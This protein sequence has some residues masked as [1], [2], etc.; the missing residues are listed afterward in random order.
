MVWSRLR[1]PA[2]FLVTA[3][4]LA[5]LTAVGCGEAATTAPEAPAT[6]APAPAATEAPAPVTATNPQAP[7]PA[8]APT[9]APTP[10]QASVVASGQMSLAWHAGL[11]S[12]WLDPQDN[13]AMATPYNFAYALHD[14]VVKIMPQALNTPSLAESWEWADDFSSITIKMRPGTSF[15]NGDP[16]TVEDVKFTFENYSG[17]QADILHGASAGVEIVDPSTIRFSFNEPFL[18]FLLLYGT[19]SSGAG[20]VVPSAYYQEVGNEGFIRAPVGAGPY[21]LL[22]EIPGDSL[23]FEAFENYHR[24]VHVKDFTMRSVQEPT[25][26]LALI[27][28]GDVDIAYNIAGELIPRVESN[29]EL[30]LVPTN[31]TAVFWLEFPHM[32]NSDNPFS[33]ARVREAVGLALDRQAI[34]D[35]ETSGHSKPANYWIPPNIL[36]APPHEAPEEDLE[37]ARQLMADAGYADGIEVEWLSPIPNYF[38]L[39]ERIISQIGRIGIS[40]KLQTMERGTFFDRLA[41]G[42]TWQERNDAWGAE[43]QILLIGTGTAGAFIAR[44]DAYVGCEAASSRMCDPEIDALTQQYKA[45]V[46]PAEREQLAGD[47]QALLSE[48]FYKIPIYWFSFINAVGPRIANR[49]NWGEGKEIFANPQMEF[50]GPPWENWKLVD[51]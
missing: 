23:R 42:D 37:K 4:A 35:A 40:A 43:T 34:S 8:A 10:A 26:R 28:A 32:H 17:A 39:G 13:P 48:R 15:H 5:L 46:D 36:L 19:F 38:S 9:S 12:S 29:E 49:D 47:A 6:S 50:Y 27:E 51:N 44:F 14:A 16:V 33:D 24:P 45:S 1:K 31:T 18:D 25:T 3:L 7:T 21:R 20:F 11:S 22:E 30:V 2:L 41:E